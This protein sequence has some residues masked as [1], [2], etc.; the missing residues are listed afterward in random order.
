MGRFLALIYGLFCYFLFLGVLLYAIW[1][2]WTMDRAQAGGSPLRA[3][4]IDAGLLALFAVQHSVMARQGFKRVWTRIVPRPVERSTYVLAADLALLA[5]VYF[6]QPVPRLVWNVQ[7]SAG[8]LVLEILFWAGWGLLVIC[9]FFVDHFDLFGLKQVWRYWKGLPYEPPHFR[10]PALYKYVR[11]PIYLAFLIA[12]WSTPR[13]TAGH[14]FF[15]VMCTGFILVA[16][17]LEERDLIHF[18]GDE[19]RDYRNRTSMLLPWLPKR[20]A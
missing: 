15:A 2:I 9:T 5:V 14:L 3:L 1:F 7:S 11:H 6:W 10:T 18:H 4:L 19:Y 20:K 12:F 13:M 8:Q 17:Q 16:I